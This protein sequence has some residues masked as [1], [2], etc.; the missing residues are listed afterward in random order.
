MKKEPVKYQAYMNKFNSYL[1]NLKRVPNY[2]IR[3]MESDIITERV[4]ED[5]RDN[6][7]K[8][9]EKS[10]DPTD[11]LAI[12]NVFKNKGKDLLS[13]Y[14]QLEIEEKIEKTKQKINANLIKEKQRSGP[15]LRQILT[16][17]GENVTGKKNKEL[18][19]LAKKQNIGLVKTKADTPE[20]LIV[21]IA[22]KNSKNVKELKEQ[23]KKL[24]K[25]FDTNPEEQLKVFKMTNEAIVE[26]LK[27]AP[28][29]RTDIYVTYSD[30]PEMPPAKSEWRKSN[31]MRLF[32]L[33]KDDFKQERNK[34]ISEISNEQKIGTRLL[35]KRIIDSE[36]LD[37]K[38]MKSLIKKTLEKKSK[39]PVMELE[40]EKRFKALKKIPLEQELDLEEKEILANQLSSPVYT[41]LLAGKKT[42][43]KKTIMKDNKELKYEYDP[44]SEY[45]PKIPDI[46]YTDEPS[47]FGVVKETDKKLKDK[48]D[49]TFKV[50]DLRNYSKKLNDEIELEREIEERKEL[51]FLTQQKDKL[52][53]S[54]K[55]LRKKKENI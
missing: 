20:E 55:E 28:R 53:K 1:G 6:T 8:K 5:F 25:E 52:E 38:A 44:F 11:L 22:A 13:N 4:K 24:K 2:D 27:P 26:P 34:I 3:K 29:K 9:L 19:T 48:F 50:G 39:Y 12:T 30:F 21:N 18:I 15:E 32:N 40:L 31:F 49:L 37:S 45:I 42:L 51:L 46:S 47:F 17:K 54:L 33:K 43:P 10:K 36:E 16:L 14:E 41:K 23:V 7:L 35:T